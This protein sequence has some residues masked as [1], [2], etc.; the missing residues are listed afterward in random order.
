MFDLD[1]KKK[2][3]IAIVALIVLAVLIIVIINYES[4]DNFFKMLSGLVS[5][6]N[7][8]FI[9][10]VLAYILN[11]LERFFSRYVLKKMKSGKWHKF[12]SIT[13]T[14]LLVIGIL[15]TFLLITI[16]QLAKSFSELPL[17]LEVFINDMSVTISEWIVSF[18]SSDFYKSMLES[19]DVDDI[20]INALFSSFLS[21]FINIEALIS[22]IAGSSM[23]IIGSI[24]SG[25]ANAIV[26]FVL[27]IYLLAS[28]EK[29]TAQGKMI[30]TAFFGK[31][32]ARK[33]YGML[34]FAD[35]TFGG[36]IQGK[37]IN[38]FIIGII[39]GICFA[40]FGLPYPQLLAIIVGVTDII[41]VFGPFIGA[42]PCAFLV[43]IA[44]PEKLWLLIL[45]IVVIQQIDGNYI[46]PKILG[47]STGLSALGVFVAIIVM[48]GYFG[49]IGMI[50]GVPLFAVI[51]AII[52]ASVE[53]KLKT[54]GLSTDIYDY[55]AKHADDLM[56]EEHDS[57]FKR[58]V[59]FIINAIKKLVVLCTKFF[60][61]LP[62]IAKKENPNKKPK[63]TIKIKKKSDAANQKDSGSDKQ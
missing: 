43:L 19:L 59:D 9:G 22:Q 32:K 44:A 33:I 15:T 24:Y 16:P 18:K 57:Y 38:S 12:L 20:D 56:V 6:L 8:V 7:S 35:R 40:L 27:S 2:K 30:T 13:L 45:L 5:V 23:E 28:K 63:D 60:K 31:E 47:E 48:G 42:V 25:T 21:T 37:I 26:G 58:V 51:L 3:I 14:Y 41:P 61:G 53:K 54:R 10:I 36:F 39:S 29:L 46:S 49:L 1:T 4:F 50:I 62:K 34:R 52:K 17:K 55:Y 11:P